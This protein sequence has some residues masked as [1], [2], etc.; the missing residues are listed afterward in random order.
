MSGEVAMD[1]IILKIQKEQERLLERREV[2][3]A[4]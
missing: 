4:K 3:N 2:V 1:K